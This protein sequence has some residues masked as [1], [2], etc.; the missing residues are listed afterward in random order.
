[1]KLVPVDGYKEPVPLVIG[2]LSERDKVLNESM[3]MDEQHG[4][5]LVAV[6]VQHFPKGATN[7]QL[8]EQSG[9]KVSTFK[10]ALACAHKEKE[11]LVGGGGRGR[12]Y[13]LNPNKCWDQASGPTSVQGH[14]H[15]GVDP[16]DPK[17]V[18]SIGPNWTQVGPLAPNRSCKNVDTTQSPETEPDLA[19][20]LEK[21]Q[22]LKNA[23]DQLLKKSNGK[24]S[25][26]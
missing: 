8:R 1:M 14:P 9:M 22:L 18:G 12:K 10:R 3:E 19:A 5:E 11:W 20:V 21:D 7:T 26:R 15:R 13:N 16:L 4:R 17:Q 25:A 2:P 6:M 23:L 24:P